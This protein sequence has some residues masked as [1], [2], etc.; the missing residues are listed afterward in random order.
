[1]GAVIGPPPLHGRFDASARRQVAELEQAA[2]LPSDEGDRD[3]GIQC[4]CRSGASCFHPFALHAVDR[5]ANA[6]DCGFEEGGI[7]LDA[8][9]ALARANRGHTG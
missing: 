8:D 5:R 6:G 4:S 9:E 2:A 7:Q 1:M 3:S